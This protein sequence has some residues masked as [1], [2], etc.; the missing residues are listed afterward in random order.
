MAIWYSV[1]QVQRR[2]EVLAGN[3]ALALMRSLEDA[4]GFANAMADTVA[5]RGLRAGVRVRA[6]SGGWLV[7]QRPISAAARARQ[8]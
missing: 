8:A 6:P 5:K 7:V 4:L 1:L 2:W 3:E